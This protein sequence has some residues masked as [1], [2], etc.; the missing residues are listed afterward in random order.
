[1]LPTVAE[2]IDLLDLEVHLTA[3]T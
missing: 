1:M 2:I 3:G